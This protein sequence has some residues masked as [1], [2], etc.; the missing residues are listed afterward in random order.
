M[1]DKAATVP[2]AQIGPSI[3]R[4]EEVSLRL[5]ERALPAFL[6]LQESAAQTV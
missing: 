5:V 6:D 3:G 4:L 2:R 1:I